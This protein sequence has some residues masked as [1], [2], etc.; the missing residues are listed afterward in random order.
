MV[1]V[2]MEEDGGPGS[3]AEGERNEELARRHRP[4]VK[5][6]LATAGRRRDQPMCIGADQRAERP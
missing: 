3:G 5:F 1:S 6:A 4:A 2:G